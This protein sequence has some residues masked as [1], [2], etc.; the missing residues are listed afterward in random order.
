MVIKLSI[1]SQSCGRDREVFQKSWGRQVTHGH[2]VFFGPPD[3]FFQ[4]DLLM[5]TGNGQIQ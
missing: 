2:T 3:V 1:P 4:M 5:D